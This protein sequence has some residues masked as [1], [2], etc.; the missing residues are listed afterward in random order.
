[1]NVFTSGVVKRRRRQGIFNIFLIF[2]QDMAHHKY[3]NGEEEIFN[4]STI[5]LSL[6]RGWRLEDEEDR[7]EEKMT[8]IS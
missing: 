2:R 7:Q 5:S 4:M 8:D 6:S 3:H 1:M